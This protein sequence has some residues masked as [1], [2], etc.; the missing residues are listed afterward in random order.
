MNAAQIYQKAIKS[1]QDEDKNLGTE[2]KRIEDE[3]RELKEQFELLFI[4]WKISPVTKDLISKLSDRITEL[5]TANL[6][7]AISPTL[8]G[9]HELISR[10][11]IEIYVLE[12]IL[13]YTDFGELKI[14]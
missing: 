14:N 4:N 13:N 7:L 3:Q 8:Q 12:K 1:E 11:L 6:I 9:R 5:T 2:K 10:N